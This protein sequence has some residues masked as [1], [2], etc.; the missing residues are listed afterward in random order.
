VVGTPIGNIADLSLRAREALAQA[1]VVAA[2]DTRRTGNLLHVLGISGKRILSYFAP[3]EAEKAEAIVA[4]LKESKTIVLVTDGGTPG[5]S[6]PGAALLRR[7]REEGARIEVVPGPS[8]V[9]AAL[10]V[11]SL[12]GARFVFEGFLPSR[13]TARRERL[14]I[15]RDDERP[16]VFFEAPHRL[17]F[18]LRDAAETLG[19]ERH[20]TL[21]REATKLYEETL[22]ATLG[23]LAGRDWKGAPKGEITLVVEGARPK[24]RS[25][26]I[27]GSD[28]AMVKLGELLVS[29]MSAGVSPERAARDAAHLTGISR[30]P[31]TRLARRLH[32]GEP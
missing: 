29:L 16:I 21:V 11:S 3:Q 8:A 5:V 12:S 25:S 6:D 10:S 27:S 20:C 17:I 1:D 14:A 2:E 26:E 18:M 22:E 19:P 24:D 15:L 23:E 31:L 13:G 9:T 28:E 30:N 32:E 4:L 7:A